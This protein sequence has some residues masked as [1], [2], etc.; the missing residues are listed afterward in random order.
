MS[1]VVRVAQLPPKVPL[2]VPF[3]VKGCNTLIKRCKKEKLSPEAVLL[4]E[5]IDQ[6][7]RHN[8]GEEEIERVLEKDNLSDQVTTWIERNRKMLSLGQGG[9]YGTLEFSV[10]PREIQEVR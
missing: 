6:L 3:G 9:V 4:D 5:V 8:Y 7:R 1:R 2:F 10:T